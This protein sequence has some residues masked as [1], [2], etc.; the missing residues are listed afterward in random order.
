VRALLRMPEGT[1]QRVRWTL[2]LL[3]LLTALTG[4]PSLLS[5]PTPG[6]GRLAGATAYG[7]VLWHWTQV[8]R[9]GG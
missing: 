6:F 2:L 8:Y 9:N 5:A 3:C 4:F 1:L 7:L